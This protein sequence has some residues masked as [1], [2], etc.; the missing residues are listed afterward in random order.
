MASNG[1]HTPGELFERMGLK[2]NTTKTQALNCTPGHMAGPESSPA[3]NDA[4]KVP[5]ILFGSDNAGALNALS[6]ERTSRQALYLFTCRHSMVSPG[7]AG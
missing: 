1:N 5:G 6:V 4:R 2:T 7:M 3:Y